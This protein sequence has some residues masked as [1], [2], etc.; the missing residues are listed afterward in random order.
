MM[1]PKHAKRTGLNRADRG[2]KQFPADSPPL[3]SRA[4]KPN[5]NQNHD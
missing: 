3:S 4:N 5:Q 1:T 2:H